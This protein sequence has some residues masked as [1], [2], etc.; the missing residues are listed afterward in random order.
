MDFKIRKMEEK[1]INQ[2]QQVAIISWHTTY[3]GI[4][5]VHV[6]DDFL[7]SAYS[8]EML[9]HRLR[10]SLMLVSA[11]KD[12][13]VGFANV[14]LLK[15]KMKAELAAIYIY[16]EYQGIGIGTQLLEE[17]IHCLSGVKE[18]YINVEKENTIGKTF[19]EAKGFKLIDEFD[20]NFDGHVLKT[21][22]M[23]LKL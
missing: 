5:P 3:N 17:A 7:R 14:S 18:I 10:N 22:R 13:I 8:N 6:Q 15:E 20:D 2:V 4:I 21:I 9:Q 1:D 12:K 16:P 19:Y 23:R 11:V